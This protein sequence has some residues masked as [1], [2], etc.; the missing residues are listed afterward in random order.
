MILIGWAALAFISLLLIPVFIYKLFD[1]FTTVQVMTNKR[2]VLSRGIFS[3][4][5]QS[6]LWEDIE[7]VSI[8]ESRMGKVFNYA[9]LSV[10]SKKGKVM[11]FNKVKDSN[12]IKDFINETREVSVC[13]NNMSM[14]PA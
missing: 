4:K 11:F 10:K 6:V 5:T 2:L 14:K 8:V 9:G 1:F 7:D 3:R 12:Y 13:M